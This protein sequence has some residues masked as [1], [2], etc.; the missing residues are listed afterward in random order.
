MLIRKPSNPWDKLKD[1]AEQFRNGD[2]R[3]PNLR[4]NI[5][6]IRGSEVKQ[7]FYCEQRLHYQYLKG[8]VNLEMRESIAR[9]IVSMVLGVSRKPK[10]T[11]WLRIPL[12]GVIDDVPIISTPDALLVED[13]KVKLI[14]KVLTTTIDKAKPRIYG[15]DRALA[16]IHMLLLD[17]LG[18][19]LNNTKYYI[20]KGPS[21][22]VFKALIE[23]RNSGRILSTY[24]NSLIYTLAY[25]EDYSRRIISWALAYWKKLRSPK[26]NPSKHK[27]IRCSYKDFCPHA[28]R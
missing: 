13:S 2:L 20:V 5:G 25:D 3:N 6:F 11:G 7:Q 27:C 21:N 4:F 22:E 14:V 1:L 17:E 8:E 18:F 19:N 10:V 23:L 15:G 9:R 24:S 16:Y 26:P 12:I 28:I